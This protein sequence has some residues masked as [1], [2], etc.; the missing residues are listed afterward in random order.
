MPSKP[1]HPFLCIFAFGIRVF[2]FER[3]LAVGQS[4]RASK[5]QLL[6]TI[7]RHACSSSSSA[8]G[9]ADLITCSMYEQLACKRSNPE[10]VI[11]KPSKRS[12]HS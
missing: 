6:P 9:T 11:I 12:F 8:P 7:T 2:V 1:P 3:G 5:F 10:F 4:S